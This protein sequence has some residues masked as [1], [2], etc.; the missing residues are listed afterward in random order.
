MGHVLVRTGPPELARPFR[1][2]E[3][4]GPLEPASGFPWTPAAN[5]SKDEDPEFLMLAAERRR[6]RCRDTDRD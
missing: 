2:R 3:E 5:L 4:D 6:D 1:E